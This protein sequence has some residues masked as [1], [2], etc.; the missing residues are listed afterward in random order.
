MA[1]ILVVEDDDN[2]RS[3]ITDILEDMD[4]RV[5][6]SADGRNALE[7]FGVAEFDLAVLDWN[8][9]GMTGPELCSALRKT[10]SQCRILM[11]TGMN[12]EEDKVHGLD[13]GADDYLTKPFLTSEFQ[14]RIRALLRRGANTIEETITLGGVTIN[15]RQ[16]RVLKNG[17]PVDL[18]VKEFDLLDFLARNR[19]TVYSLDA[20]IRYVWSSDEDVSYDAVRQCVTRVRRKLDDDN[21]ESLISTVVGIGYKIN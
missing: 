19:G 14:A 5:E 18:K 11:L 6:T 20:L 8:M 16:R 12:R 2:I 4:H 3:S 15:S 9:P 1:K 10:G 21:S 7:L 13:S 17:V